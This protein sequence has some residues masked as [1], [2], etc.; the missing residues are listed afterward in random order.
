MSSNIL[1][2][3]LALEDPLLKVES[4]ELLL[5]DLCTCE[6]D[7]GLSR[8]AVWP[9]TDV[10]VLHGGDVVFGDGSPELI[11]ESRLVFTEIQKS[12]HIYVIQL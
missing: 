8:G 1:G 4:S 10:S 5:D 3:G 11:P 12:C 2:L 7:L 9:S 6:K